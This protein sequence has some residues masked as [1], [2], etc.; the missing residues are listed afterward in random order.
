MCPNS[1]FLRFSPTTKKLVL[2]K[3][4]Y[5]KKRL[6]FINVHFQQVLILLATALKTLSLK[7]NSNIVKFIAHATLSQF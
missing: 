1:N 4:G 2:L 5:E 6:F 7:K 3:M